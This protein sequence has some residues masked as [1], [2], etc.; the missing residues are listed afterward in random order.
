MSNFIKNL[1][2]PDSGLAK[3][4]LLIF[5]LFF[6]SLEFLPFLSPIKK[7][8]AADA[9]SISIGES[10]FSAYLIN[11]FAPENSI[12]PIAITARK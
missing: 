2:K 12:D 5:V 9:L 3:F 1:L 10:S 4:L 6:F 11:F 8:L 7:F